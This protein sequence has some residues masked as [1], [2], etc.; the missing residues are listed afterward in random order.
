MAGGRPR[1]ALG[2]AALE[3]DERLAPGGAGEPRHQLVP[4]GDPLDVRQSDRCRRVVGVEVE[5]VGD[6]DGGCVAGRDG[7]A[8][9]DASGTREVHEARHEVPALARHRDPT[10]RRV[11]GDDLGAQ[12]G[13]RR[14]HAL[15][16]RPGEQDPELVGER[17]ELTLGGATRFARLAVAG[18]RQERRP[19]SLGGAGAEDL[20]VGGGRRADEHEV[21]RAVGEIVDVGHGAHAEHLLALQVGAEDAARVPAGEQVVQGDEAELAGVRRGA[22]DEHTAR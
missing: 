20:G 7:T 16:V 13:G 22:G 18:R 9:A 3:H 1:T 15:P 11:R 17:D 10:G 8:D 19:H 14:Y 2:G 12:L 4:V 6:R 5:V 21:D